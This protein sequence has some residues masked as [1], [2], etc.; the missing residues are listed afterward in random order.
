MSLR[1]RPPADTHVIRL[2]TCPF[3]ATTLFG[4]DGNCIVAARRATTSANK[5]DRY[6]QMQV[7]PCRAR[8]REQDS[9]REMRT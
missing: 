5:Y 9:R 8:E 7:D 1:M 4:V 6:G 3:A 2:S